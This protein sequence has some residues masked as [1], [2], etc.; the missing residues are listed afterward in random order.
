MAYTAPYYTPEQ[1]ALM[2]ENSIQY[3]Y[4]STDATYIGLDHQYE[5]TSA[6]FLERG[7]NLQLKLPGNSP[8]KVNDFL[9][10]LRL[11]FYTR[12]YNKNKSSRNQLNFLI[13]KRGIYGWTMEEYRK[14]FLEA[15][16]IEGCYLAENGDISSVAGIDLDTMQNMSVDVVRNQDRDFHKDS[17]DL[18]TTMG[19]TY[20]GRY[21]FIPQ[22]KDW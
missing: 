8:T 5:L 7:V 19:L 16:F 1:L 22:G 2:D 13:A 10:S 4:S 17:L 9:R 15:M 20:Y 12:I 11:K 3:P 21:K 6:Y 18:L 14:T